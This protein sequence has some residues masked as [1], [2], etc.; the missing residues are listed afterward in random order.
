ML[1]SPSVP[2]SGTDALAL[3]SAI[4]SML[5]KGPQKGLSKSLETVR[6]PVVMPGLLWHETE[7]DDEG[8]PAST[9]GPIMRETEAFAV[10]I[11]FGSGATLHA[12]DRV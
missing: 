4:A 1:T 8:V 11:W 7:F 10:A 12:T 6:K 5:T 2:G 9:P 3:V